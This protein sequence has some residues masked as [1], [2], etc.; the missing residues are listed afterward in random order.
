MPHSSDFKTATNL[1]TIYDPV[2][3]REML[4][5]RQHTLSYYD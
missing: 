5:E 2:A 3:P 4:K 1:A